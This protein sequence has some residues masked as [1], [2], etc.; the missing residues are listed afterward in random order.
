[1]RRRAILFWLAVL[2]LVVV[3]GCGVSVP[4][5]DQ[6]ESVDPPEIESEEFVPESKII[7]I[8]LVGDIMVHDAQI[9]SAYNAITGEYEFDGSF[10]AIAPYLKRADVVIGNLE[11]TLAGEH[12]VYGGYPRFNSPESLAGALKRAGFTILTTAN[13]H[14]LD[15][16][17]E[18][19]RNTLDYL[20]QYG[21]KH[22]GT[23]RS[24]EERQSLLI[25][26]VQGIQLGILSYT[27]GTNGLPI[28]AGQEYLVNL[29]DRDAMARDI[30]ELR[31]KE[32]DLILTFLHFGNEYQKKLSKEQKELVDWLQSQGVECILGSH[33]HVLQPAEFDL[34][35]G[36][37]VIYSLGNF[38][39]AQK[40]LERQSSAVYY[41]TVVQDHQG[42]TRLE[43][44]SFLPIYTY[45]YR[46]QGKFAVKVLPLSDSFLQQPGDWDQEL[47][48]QARI[49]VMNVMRTENIRV[50][51]EE[52]KMM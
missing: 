52:E 35:N 48:H 5:S 19:V 45:R 26:S 2:A 24:Q 18:G 25:Y 42:L 32:V 23:A 39:S 7:T 51:A 33:P 13:N 49:E 40:G 9:D 31:R 6:P 27:Y 41:L 3:S 20:D 8:A 22:A 36:Y 28:P 17:A 15:R 4:A 14:C 47:L 11:T 29:I 44:V 12:L 38:I 43:A 10:E 30:E 46:E 50:Y 16:G 21:L 34:E 37:L 1:M